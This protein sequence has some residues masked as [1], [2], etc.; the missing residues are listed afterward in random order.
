MNNGWDTPWENIMMNNPISPMLHKLQG[1][2]LLIVGEADTMCHLNL[3]IG[4]PM[5]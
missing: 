4:W 3:L 1:D 5:H 2:L